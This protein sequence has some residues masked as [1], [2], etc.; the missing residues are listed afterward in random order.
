MTTELKPSYDVVISG[1]GPCG[2]T[3]ANMLG[4]QGVS[5][6]LIDKEP[7][8]ID[9]PRAVGMCDEGSRI[10]ASAGVF[11]HAPV[12]FVEVSRTN[13]TNAK[14]EPV[15]HF[16][17]K[18]K[19]NSNA[20]QRTFYQPQLENSIR[21]AFKRFSCVDFFPSSELTHFTDNGDSVDL[22]IQRNTS[23]ENISCKYLVGCDGAS[24]PVRKQ[25]GIGFSGKTYRQD[26]LIIDIE[27]NPL[28]NDEIDFSI[29]PRRPGITLPL[30]HHKRR[31]EFVVKK[32][33]DID[34]LFS[35]ETLSNLLA[36]WGDIDDMVLERKAIYSFHARTA[37]NY[38]QGNVF[39]A[40]DAAHIT[41]P[42]AGQGMM[43]GLRDAQ[44]LSWKLAGVI[45]QTL[46]KSVLNSYDAERVPQS[47]QIIKFAQMIGKLILPQ[48][49]L[50]VWLRDGAIA[51][52]TATGIYRKSSGL[53]MD[54]IPNHING[55]LLRNF[56]ISK[57]KGT[58]TW[59]PQYMLSCQGQAKPSDEWMD[60]S[61]Y[62]INWNHN[63]SDEISP[64]TQKRWSNLDGRFI[65]IYEHDSGKNLVDINH[66]YQEV[67]GK[68]DTLVI[69]PD[70]MIVINCKS[71]ELETQLNAYLD[72][73]CIEKSAGYKKTAATI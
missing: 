29:D 65:N 9:I 49:R 14:R 63:G 20:M 62:I 67:F 38:T 4:M 2:A 28:D 12:D 56:W 52:M 64:A 39:L 70:K 5:T 58:G 3:I 37:T 55:S 7:D 44:N 6:L 32:H 21:K 51:L 57:T 17:M 31:W 46:D 10:L 50:S 73:I 68:G 23:T 59:F 13:F 1:A 25:L 40:G 69:R 36:H 26:W 11:K 41:P 27:K 72:K 18:K 47:K 24:S 66:E 45:N 60:D 61:F 30:P 34:K 22:T 48:S 15:F 8:I 19:I 54:K 33:D 35:N 53:N 16:D 71:S 42:F 43:A